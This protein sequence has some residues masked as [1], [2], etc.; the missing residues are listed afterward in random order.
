MEE[1]SDVAVVEALRRQL[2]VAATKQAVAA[3]NL[4]NANTP[5]F[6]AKEVRFDEVLDEGLAQTTQPAATHPAHFQAEAPAVAVGD[7]A[8]LEPRR[9]GNNVQLDRE[10]LAMAD[11]SA[12][13]A[14]AQTALSAKFRLVRYAINEGR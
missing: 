4:A 13:F 1:L 14:R 3:G 7:A 5:D 9:D 6:R 12:E 2:S 10:L 11:A 8:G